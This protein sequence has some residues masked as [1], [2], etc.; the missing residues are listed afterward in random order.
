MD[1]DF[2]YIPKDDKQYTSLMVINKIY[3]I[4]INL[5]VRKLGTNQEK[6]NNSN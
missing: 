4:Q 5:L 6:F 1:D 2:I 3:L